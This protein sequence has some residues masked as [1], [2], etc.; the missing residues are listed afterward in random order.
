[1]TDEAGTYAVIAPN[2]CKQIVAFQATMQHMADNFPGAFEGYSMEIKESHQSTK[3][4]TSGTAK[5]MV[6][7]FTKVWR[8]MHTCLLTHPGVPRFA[9]SLSL[10][11]GS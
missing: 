3:A 9:L 10:S 6:G 1:M 4:D 5:A 2:M 7:H 11:D 8:H